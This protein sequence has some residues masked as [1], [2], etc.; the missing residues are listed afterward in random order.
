MR[1][2]HFPSLAPLLGAL[3]GPG[4]Q[5]VGGYE[6]FEALQ[7]EP[8]HPCSVLP[9]RKTGSR[10]QVLVR[11][12]LSKTDCVWIDETEV[13]VSDY[14]G[15]LDENSDFDGWDLTYCSWKEAGASNPSRD[16]DDEC[17]LAIPPDE[18]DPFGAMKPIRCVDWCDA[19]SFCQENGGHLCYHENGGGSLEPEGFASEW[20]SACSGW[21]DDL[22]RYPWGDEPKPYEG[23]CN[24]AQGLPGTTTAASFSHGPSPVGQLSDCASPR[25]AFDLIGNVA[26]WIAS[27]AKRKSEEEETYD[28]LS[29]KAV[30]GS[31]AAISSQ[32]TC[33]VG[34]STRNVPRRERAKDIGFR[35]CSDL[36]AGERIEID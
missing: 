32:A 35:C 14:E 5:A 27:C 28:L 13:T 8:P 4:C 15:W 10:G 20:Q 26:E 25:G 7:P 29:C 19:F 23:V 1:A 17:G 22:T 31:Y 6:D 36:N 11:V 16:P 9:T 30:G 33:A 24:V 2:A 21:G 3:L 12:E 18:S 34:P